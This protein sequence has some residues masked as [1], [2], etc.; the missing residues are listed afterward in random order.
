[1]KHTCWINYESRKWVEAKMWT[2]WQLFFKSEV[3]HY[4]SSQEAQV[5]QPGNRELALN[6][7]S[8]KNLLSSRR[9]P[10]S[11]KRSWDML[12]AMVDSNSNSTE[13][14]QSR[15]QSTQQNPWNEVPSLSTKPKL[16]V[17]VDISQYPRH[18]VIG[19]Q[20]TQRP[21][22]HRS[23]VPSSVLARTMRWLDLGVL[24]FETTTCPPHSHHTWP[25]WTCFPKSNEKKG[26]TR[27]DRPRLH[28]Q[29]NCFRGTQ[30][31]VIPI[32]VYAR[33]AWIGWTECPISI[34]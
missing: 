20:K 13:Q 10:R 25:A 26:K 8:Q 34:S 3:Q 5:A 2:R 12:A 22:S 17:T 4:P 19:T 7:C 21:S 9:C 24:S 16:V 30:K 31:V 18:Q 28:Q 1:M 6:S 23:S 15:K 27:R 14:P 11:R 32:Y 33:C 29:H